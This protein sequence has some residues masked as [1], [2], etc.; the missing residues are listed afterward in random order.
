MTRSAL[1]VIVVALLLNACSEPQ[2]P[3]QPEQ[4]AAETQTPL[5]EQPVE[6]EPE[7]VPDSDQPPGQAILYRCDD[8]TEFEMTVIG[9]SAHM[10]L[11]N[12]SY[13]MRQQPA[14][15]G[16]YH[17]GD[18]W[19]VHSKG[20]TALLIGPDSTR[21]CDQVAVRDVEVPPASPVEATD[22]AAAEAETGLE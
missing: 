16:I 2:S 22:S 5:A 3:Q 6:T 1:S 9:S 12:T 21:E 4:P 8:G 11:D 19:Q 7:A 14:A 17:A 20:E 10:E 15:S 13:E 18:L